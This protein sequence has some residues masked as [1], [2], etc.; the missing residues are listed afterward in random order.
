MTISRLGMILR[1]KPKAGELLCPILSFLDS[2]FHFRYSLVRV[3]FN[4]TEHSHGFR[5]EY[6]EKIINRGG[7]QAV[8][9]R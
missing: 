2:R 6:V 5:K 3:G 4:K 9:A 8:E 1:L 7:N